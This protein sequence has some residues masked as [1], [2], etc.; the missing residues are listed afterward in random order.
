MTV[1]ERPQPLSEREKEILNLLATGA[2]NQEIARALHISPNTVKVHLRN[3]YAKL[4]V[5][6]RSEAIM[7]GLREGYILL[8]GPEPSRPTTTEPITLSEMP[9][10]MPYVGKVLLFSTFLATLAVLFLALW[11]LWAGTRAVSAKDATFTDMTRPSTG[12]PLRREVTRWTPLTPMTQPRSRMAVAVWQGKVFVF[13]G[14]GPNG[15]LRSAAVFDPARGVWDAITPLPAPISNAQAAVVANRIYLFGGTN[16]NLQPTDRILVYDPVQDRWQDG[17]RLP[18]PLAGYGLAMWQDTIYLFGGW[19][20][21][22]YLATVYAFDP[23]T[24]Q[25]YTLPPL[26]GQRAF[27]ATVTT[28]TAIYLLGGFDG[29]MDLAEVWAFDPEALQRGLHPWSSLPAMLSPRGG[30]W[31]AAIGQAIYVVGGGVA[32]VVDGAERYDPITGTWARINT[33][34]GPNWRHMGGALIGGDLLLVGGWAGSVLP[35]VEQY[36]VSFRQFIPYGP[37][38]VIPQ[39]TD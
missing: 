13:G 39:G 25:W 29:Q 2:T 9:V 17:G 28:E 18:H 21:E 8:P 31:A 37:V 36:R 19:D 30:A 1:L 12:L 5:T 24:G 10:G 14:E 38:N 22:Q 11:P 27:P 35:F 4:G 33:P 26:P 34:Y 16:A 7:V 32:V 15:V 20:G 3:I 6:N 23:E